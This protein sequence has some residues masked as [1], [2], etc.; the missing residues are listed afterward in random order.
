L[1]V[2]RPE[3]LAASA[4]LL[5]LTLQVSDG[6]LSV[7][8]VVGL[9]LTFVALLMAVG[10]R[11]HPEEAAR[12]RLWTSIGLLLQFGALLARAPGMYLEGG[13][14]LRAVFPAVI[15]LMAFLAGMLVESA[16]PRSPWRFPVLVAL[17]ALAC[18]WMLV[19]SPSPQ[20][21]VFEFQR[22]AGRA[23]IQ[24]RN[25]YAITFRNLYGHTLFYGPGFADAQ[26][27]QAGFPYLPLSLLLA[28]AG[29]LLVGD[30]R[31]VQC[32]ALILTVLLLSRAGGRWAL[33]AALL[34]ASTP[35]LFFVLEQS[36]TEP[37]LL[38][39]LV[40]TVLAAERRSKWLP[41][42]FGLLLACKQTAL[43]FVP[44]VPLL[45]GR[46]FGVRRLLVFLGQ[47]AG[48]ALLITL[49]LALW[50]PA[51]FFR[52]VVFWQLVQPF[53]SDALSYLALVGESGIPN[54]ISLV[55]TAS[56]TLLALLYGIR[57]LPWTPAG[58]CA[59]AALVTFVFFAFNKQAF[60]NYDFLVLGTMACALAVSRP[61]SEPTQ[62]TSRM[63]RTATSENAQPASAE[64]AS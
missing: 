50:N 2:P 38:A 9:T 52:S 36:W 43:L 15:G 10:T 5:G 46:P 54:A 59:G 47:A 42:I 18:G 56:V 37:I 3:W 11:P 13:P 33:L 17:F 31:A 32:L 14:V 35:R 62:T 40:G 26:T 4:I 1:R 20:I 24:G 60:A 22:E 34:F 16:W 12:V 8:G 51:A 48:V 45:L 30:P 44:L 61:T 39:L 53:R 19:A 23:L 63:L 27:I 28:T 29:E 58:F 49:P 55:I 57:R 6:H 64:S 25:P 7:A 41:L 21:D